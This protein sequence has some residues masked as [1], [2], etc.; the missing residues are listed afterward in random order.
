M[1]TDV[2][3]YGDSRQ[4]M[5]MHGARHHLPLVTHNA[6]HLAAMMPLRPHKPIVGLGAALLL[7]GTLA[8]IWEV[9]ACQAPGTALFIGML[10]G[11]ISALRELAFS[12]GLLLLITS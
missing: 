3:R 8:G 12:L 4:C 11:P 9:L 5:R 1:G 7:C 6:L 10:P 2:H